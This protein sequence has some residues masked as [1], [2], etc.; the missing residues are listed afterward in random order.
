[1]VLPRL[2]VVLPIVAASSITHP[3]SASPALSR[4]STEQ[5]RAERL[6]PRSTS[7]TTSS[8]SSSSS[9]WSSSDGSNDEPVS[10]SQN[11]HQAA[12]CVDGACSKSTSHWNSDPQHFEV[13]RFMAFQ[14][15]RMPEMDMKGHASMFAHPRTIFSERPFGSIKAQGDEVDAV[16]QK[17][18]KVNSR[19][20]EHMN[21]GRLF[22]PTNHDSLFRPDFGASRLRKRS[23]MASPGRHDPDSADVL[24]GNFHQI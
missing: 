12:N 2:I 23:A 11:T 14:R 10:F 21:I 3:S 22:E 13:P 8:S 19:M 1:M 4:R 18:N 6:H 5:V 24:R 20:S 15:G 7:Y 9:S 17:L 16:Q